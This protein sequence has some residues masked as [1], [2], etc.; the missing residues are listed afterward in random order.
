MVD[1]DILIAG[2]GVNGLALALALDQFGFA[3]TLADAEIEAERPRDVRAYALA[4]TSVNLMRRLGVWQAIAPH[5]EPMREVKVSD[6][7]VGPG[8]SPLS[9]EFGPDDAGGEPP[10]M[11]VEQR[12]I[13]PALIEALKSSEVTVKFGAQVSDVAVGRA[14]VSAKIGTS[15]QRARLIVAADGRASAL[16]AAAGIKRVG[17]GYGQSA[18]VMTLAH[19]APHNGVAHQLFTPAGPL[20]LLPLRDNRTCVVWTER[21]EQAKALLALSSDQLLTAFAPLVGDA[22]GE[23]SIEAGPA[24][25]PLQLSIAERFVADRLALIGDAAHVVHPLAG[26][27]LNAGLKDVAALAEVL[28]DA[29]RR[30]EDIGRPEVL[31]RYE[32]WRRFDVAQL[33]M[34]TDTV[35]RAFSN[36]NPALR[37]GRDLALGLISRLG[38]LRR[39]LAREAM[40]ETGDLPR[41]LRP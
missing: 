36:D 27:G 10:G 35:N 20:A 1:C 13:R 28:G 12:H 22:L 16:G 26:Q 38:G 33:A 30:G 18:I 19:T 24:S 29:A 31:A 34:M 4:Q 14:S 5:A 41:L 40:G 8:A 11:M 37:A 7:R 2:G 25:F 15:V 6:G 32:S 23:I 9:L 21:S 3:V 39:T 17:W